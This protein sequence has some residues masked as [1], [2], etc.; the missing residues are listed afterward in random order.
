MSRT[1][2]TRVRAKLRGAAIAARELGIDPTGW[3]LR[4]G[5]PTTG[6]PYIL[7]I[8]EEL[9]YLGQTA[10]QAYLSLEVMVKTL[11]IAGD[12]LSRAGVKL[13]P[14]TPVSGGK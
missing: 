8:G 14:I 1:T 13:T 4:E 3:E 10:P 12:K 11:S 7:I 9:I 2:V 5:T 6:E